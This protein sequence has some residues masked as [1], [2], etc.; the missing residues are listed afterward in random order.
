MKKT[1]AY[2]IFEPRGLNFQIKTIRYQK[3]ICI[4]DFLDANGGYDWADLQKIGWSCKKVT[5]NF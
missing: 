4:A 5:I 3:K 1:T 2:A